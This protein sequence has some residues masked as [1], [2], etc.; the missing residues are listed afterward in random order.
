MG[1]PYELVRHVVVVRFQNIIAC[2]RHKITSYC[3]THLRLFV[4]LRR[5][6]FWRQVHVVPPSFLR[7]ND[8]T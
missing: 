2:R 3:C 6:R 5:V 8:I 7:R 4:G 1:R